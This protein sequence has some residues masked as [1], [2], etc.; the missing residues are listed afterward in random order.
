M[1]AITTAEEIA[2]LRR[3]IQIYSAAEK[4]EVVRPGDPISEQSLE[5][6]LFQ[7]KPFIDK[8][9]S[10][11]RST[12]YKTIS[13]TEKLSLNDLKSDAKADIGKAMCYY[14]V[15][16]SYVIGEDRSH[17]GFHRRVANFFIALYNDCRRQG[18][19]GDDLY[20]VMMLWFN[21]RMGNM[22]LEPA[23]AALVAYLFA[24]C[25]IFEKTEEEKQV[26]MP[27]AEVAA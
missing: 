24:K 19:F 17:P 25:D 2:Q 21:R 9:D 27:I 16:D 6:A 10:R 4:W 23:A 3:E 15:V 13:I 26:T 5:E 11:N 20:K 1:E 8:V 12:D 22:V 7:L 14:K 18:F